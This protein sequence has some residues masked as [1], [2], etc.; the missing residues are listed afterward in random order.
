MSLLPAEIISEKILIMRWV[1]VMLD[2]AL[3]KL[4]W[5]ET[6]VL[7]QSVTRNIDLFPEDFMFQLTKQEFENWKSQ[8]VTS[9]NGDRMWRR[10]SPRVF[11]EHWIAMLSCVLKSKQARITNIA[12]IRVFTHMRKI[13]SSNQE[14]LTKIEVLERKILDNN[15][16]I[17]QIRFE[18]KKMLVEEEDKVTKIGLE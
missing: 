18:I 12:I 5:V 17:Q 3:D 10:K 2:R 13:L 6:K 1:K 4:Y 9:N 8:S 7:N 11:T 15:E 14:I 16:N